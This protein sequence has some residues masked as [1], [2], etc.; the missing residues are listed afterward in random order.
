MYYH[1][2]VQ[3]L[4]SLV[5]VVSSIMH[6][7][8]NSPVQ[9]VPNENEKFFS[10]PA[11][12]IIEHQDKFEILVAVPGFKKENITI[13]LDKNALV[14][15]GENVN[16]NVKFKHKE[17]NLERFKR[18]FT[19]STL[20]DKQNITANVVNGILSISILKAAEAQP[21]NIEIL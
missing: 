19:L 5:P 16:Q 7:V 9:N 13:K 1:P 2:K 18:T 15:T 17:F 10:T 4:G 14:V 8:L 11:A 3:S 6:E 21:K 20:M 12:N